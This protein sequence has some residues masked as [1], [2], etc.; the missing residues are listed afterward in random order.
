MG[1]ALARTDARARRLLA[2]ASDVTGVDVPRALE[3]GG[4]A[5]TR[6]E[7][8]QPVLVA[9]GLGFAYAWCE[10]EGPPDVVLGHSLGELTA[11]A[12]AIHLPDEC[13]ISLARTRGLAM[14]EAAARAPGGMLAIRA[15]REEDLAPLLAEGLALAA[16][17]APDEWVLSGSLEALSRAERMAVVETRRLVVSGPWHHP[18]MMAAALVPLRAALEA[19]PVGSPRAA[20]VSAVTTQPVICD[21]VAGVLLESLVRPVRWSETIDRLVT[22]GLESLVVVPPSRVLTGLLRRGSARAL[23]RP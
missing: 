19:V 5:L 1:L 9:V 6:T 18:A 4:R 21:D 22:L 17:N 11:A 16:V 13:A 20:F 15:H 12:Y 10:R 14:A 23:V 8:I 7:V 3:H 2:L